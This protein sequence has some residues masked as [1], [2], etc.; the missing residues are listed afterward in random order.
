MKSFRRAIYLI[1]Q[2][3]IPGSGLF[4]VLMLVNEL[5]LKPLCLNQKTKGYPLYLKL[6]VVMYGKLL[7]NYKIMI[8]SRKYFHVKINGTEKLA[9]DF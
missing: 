8:F 6:V 1:K 3:N 4:E 2:Q 7:S 9:A 5:M